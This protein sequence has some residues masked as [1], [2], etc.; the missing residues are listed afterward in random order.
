MTINNAQNVSYWTCLAPCFCKATIAGGDPAADE[1]SGNGTHKPFKL[2]TSLSSTHV[3]DSA[4][5]VK[6]NLN[7]AW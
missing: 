7:G 2:N 6:P 5:N 4:H 3:H 1:N